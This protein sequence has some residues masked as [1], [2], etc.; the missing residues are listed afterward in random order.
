MRDFEV[1]R[2]VF[3]HDVGHAECIGSTDECLGIVGAQR[4]A[5]GDKCFDVAGYDIGSVTFGV[6]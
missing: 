1:T 4:D 5:F 2:V 6:D 3:L